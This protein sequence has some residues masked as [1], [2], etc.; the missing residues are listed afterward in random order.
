MR[1]L[2]QARE[3]FL[4]AERDV[5]RWPLS[6]AAND[7]RAWAYAEWLAAVRAFRAQV[8][9]VDPVETEIP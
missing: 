7:R 6:R 3:T 5:L 4:E 8:R 9:S 1:E 2:S